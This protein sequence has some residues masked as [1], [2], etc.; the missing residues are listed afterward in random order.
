MWPTVPPPKTPA[1]AL[2]NIIQGRLSCRPASLPR[3]EALEQLV[4]AYGEIN[5]H[6]RRLRAQIE[7]SHEFEQFAQP[8]HALT[9][10][11]FSY[12]DDLET[13]L[14]GAGYRC[15]QAAGRGEALPPAAQYWLE[16][17]PR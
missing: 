6:V 13:L 2:L 14:F 17:P 5:G 4:L 10:E 9:Y 3:D 16:H 12:L 8:P 1:E 7:M 11:L 15:G